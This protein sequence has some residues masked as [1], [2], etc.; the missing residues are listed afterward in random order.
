[1]NERRNSIRIPKAALVNLACKTGDG[2]ITTEAMA[3]NISMTGMRLFLEKPLERGTQLS[4]NI[5]FISFDG[6]MKHDSIEGE[7]V[8]CHVIDNLHFLGIRFNQEIH[9]QKQPLLYAH[10]NT[11]ISKD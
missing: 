10:L 4:M 8:Y 11:M 1:M 5:H 2:D 9:P 3:V 6:S 7:I